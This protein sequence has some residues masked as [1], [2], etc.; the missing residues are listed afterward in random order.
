MNVWV[1]PMGPALLLRQAPAL[2]GGLVLLTAVVRAAVRSAHIR[3]LLIV[4]LP[5]TGLV[6]ETLPPP[7]GELA[8]AD[9]TRS[10]RELEPPLEGKHFLSG[11]RH[12]AFSIPDLYLTKPRNKSDPG[13]NGRC[14]RN[15]VA[16]DVTARLAPVT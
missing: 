3:V 5:L 15:D 13:C 4:P 11:H 16:I 12:D 14:A 6:A 1:N 9:G 10:R 2:R 8:S 7:A